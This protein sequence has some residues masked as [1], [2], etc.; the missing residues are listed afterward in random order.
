MLTAVLPSRPV[1]SRR[2][3]RPVPFRRY[4][5]SRPVSI[6]YG[7]PGKHDRSI[8]RDGTI[9]TAFV[10][11]RPIPPLPS[12]RYTVYPVP[13]VYRVIS[14]ENMTGAACEMGPSWPRF[15]RPAPPPSAPFRSV[16]PLPV[17]P[18]PSVYRDISLRKHGRRS[19][20]DG[21]R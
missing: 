15:H 12:H 11:S 3:Y 16:P 5:Q 10:P 1:P 6:L 8:M 17:N 20:R 7:M 9:L 4:R 13:I 14:L 21:C 19:L 2:F 18:V